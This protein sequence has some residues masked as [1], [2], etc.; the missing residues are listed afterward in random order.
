MVWRRE[1]HIK[2]WRES[3]VRANAC[4]GTNSCLACSDAWNIYLHRAVGQSQINHISI[5]QIIYT[6]TL[7]FGR[8]TQSR[9]NITIQLTQVALFHVQYDTLADQILLKTLF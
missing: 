1:R 3:T 2:C 5:N 7:K 8:S 6:P 4:C 9:K